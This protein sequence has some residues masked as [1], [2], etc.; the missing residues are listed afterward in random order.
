[1]TPSQITRSTYGPSC[2]LLAAITTCKGTKLWMGFSVWKLLRGS[3]SDKD[4]VSSDCASEHPMLS[5]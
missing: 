4:A 3:A 5:T 2:S 1:M